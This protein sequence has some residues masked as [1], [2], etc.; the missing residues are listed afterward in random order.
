MTVNSIF[1]L[2]IVYQIKHLLADYPLQGRYMLGKFKGG[3]DW[4]MPLL[5]HV[6]VHAAFTTVIALFYVPQHAILLGALDATI[7]FIMDRIK[8]SPNMLGRFQALSKRE[9]MEVIEHFKY[10]EQFPLSNTTMQTK[11]QE[12]AKVKSNTYFWWSLGLDQMVHH[13]THYG[14]I[15]IIWMA[16]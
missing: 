14:I 2:L 3:T 6:G 7:H 10:F 4:I 11:P 5:A 16:S 12:V 8:A 9:M 1:I 15:Y 13:L